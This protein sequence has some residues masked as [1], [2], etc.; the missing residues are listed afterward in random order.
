M[1]HS[2]VYACIIYIR[3][4]TN[5]QSYACYLDGSVTVRERNAREDSILEK[6]TVFDKVLNESKAVSANMQSLVER[7]GE[8]IDFDGMEV[9]SRMVSMVS[10]MKSRKMSRYAAKAKRELKYVQDNILLGY[11]DIET[12]TAGVGGQVKKYIYVFGVPR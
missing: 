1:A 3:C 6:L 7:M 12:K 4:A 5:L 2:T 8:G 11:I 9:T 10:E